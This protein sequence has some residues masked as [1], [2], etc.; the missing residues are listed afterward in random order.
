MHQQGILARYGRIV[1]FL[2]M[3]KISHVVQWPFIV[4]IRT[5]LNGL[6]IH[7]VYSTIYGNIRAKLG[8]ELTV[9][10]IVALKAELILHRWLAT[11]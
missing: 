10:P 3:R 9:W 4:R 2:R 11:C 7:K 6:C 5:Y 8:S 1:N